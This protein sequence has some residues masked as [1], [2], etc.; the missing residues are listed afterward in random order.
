M[1]NTILP[2]SVRPVGE[3]ITLEQGAIPVRYK[4]FT[5]HY[6]GSGTMA[7][8]L[9]LQYIKKRS[10]KAEC[11]IMLPAYACPDLVSACVGASVTPIL[12]DLEPE[13][14]FPA[15][16]SIKENM[17]ERTAGVVL[18]NFLGLSP[19][20]SLFESINALGL[21]TVEDRAQCFAAASSADQ[22][23]GDH[24]IFSFGKGKP[25]SLL[26]G[27][28][29]LSR[30]TGADTNISQ[31][32]EGGD[33]TPGVLQMKQPWAFQVKVSLYNA[34]IRPFFYYCLLKVPGLAIG[35]THYKDPEPI[36]KLPLFKRLM[37]QPNIQKQDGT[38]TAAQLRLAQLTSSIGLQAIGDQPYQQRL[39]RLPLLANDLNHRD[40]VL[41]HL[42]ARGIGASAMY[43][44]P[45]PGVKGTPLDE[46]QCHKPYPNA[47]NFADR[48]ITLPCHSGVSN[49]DLDRVASAVAQLKD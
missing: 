19:P 49:L 45:L 7:L 16:A 48:L 41:E 5:E 46:V 33:E 3:P 23:L 32:V 34:V 10:G 40:R 22:L 25:I 18:V 47:Q 13:T 21:E 17:T 42:N 36:D 4:G 6:V 14:P 12:V 39:L 43:N 27:G 44:T 11:E 1:L 37:I 24:V 2:R 8:Q 26:G 38:N 9:A 35:E 20:P 29:T 15:L 28:L 30:S 31:A